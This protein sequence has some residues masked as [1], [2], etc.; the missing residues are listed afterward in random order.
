MGW[1][2]QETISSNNT[3]CGDTDPIKIEWARQGRLRGTSDRDIIRQ[4]LQCISHSIVT[5]LI[6]TGGE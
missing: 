3:H 4:P 1:L 6:V 5:K 2:D